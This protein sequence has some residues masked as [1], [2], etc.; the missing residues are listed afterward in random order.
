MTEKSLPDMR[1]PM[2]LLAFGFGSGLMPKAPGTFGTLVGIP[3]YL[4]I[5]PLP[6]SYYLMLVLLAFVAGI[7]ICQ[8]TSDDLG[9][10]DHG[11]I[12]W[13]EIVGYL[14]TMA[15]APAG[16]V[17][18]L[19]GFLLFRLFDIVKPWPIRWI[20]RKVDGGFGIMLDDL[21]AGIFAAVTMAL[22]H[23]LRWL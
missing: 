19:V 21:L 20:D 11:G 8:K 23:L 15:F 4:V 7:W 6:Q 22:L 9:V 3:L 5:E 10:H 1:K 18:I 12:V 17:W 14:V 16:W 2:H 13:D